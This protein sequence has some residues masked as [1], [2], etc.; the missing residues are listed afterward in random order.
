MGYPPRS[1]DFGT[2]GKRRS[3]SSCP[4]INDLFGVSQA[5]L[6]AQSLRYAKK[7]TTDICLIFRGLFFSHALILEKI[8]IL[9]QPPM[10]LR[11]HAK[12]SLHF[13][14]SDLG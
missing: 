4:S 1:F 13:R 5:R 14:R 6:P 12:I 10:K 8:A 7:I 2:T 3:N 11:V 9:G